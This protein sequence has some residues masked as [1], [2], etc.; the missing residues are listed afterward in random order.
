MI[1]KAE[2]GLLQRLMVACNA[3]G[4]VMDRTAVSE[5]RLFDATRAHVLVSNVLYGLLSMHPDNEYA[6]AGMEKAMD[7]LDRLEALVD[8]DYPDRNGY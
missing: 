8:K 2:R 7:S 4:S 3:I 1:N 6:E 5:S